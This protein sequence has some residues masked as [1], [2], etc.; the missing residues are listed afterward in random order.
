MCVRVCITVCMHQ[1]CVSLCVRVCVYCLFPHTKQVAASGVDVCT[2]RVRPHSFQIETTDA[3]TLRPGRWEGGR[4]GGVEGGGCTW[5]GRG[6][7][8]LV[9]MCA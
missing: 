4:V 2:Q 6:K 1:C 7:V 5:K 8:V 3:A 9:C